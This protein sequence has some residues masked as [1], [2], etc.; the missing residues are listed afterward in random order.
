MRT[1]VSTLGYHETR[2]T[3]PV[4]SNGIDAGDQIVLVRPTSGTTDHRAQSAASYVAD[5]IQE[6]APDATVSTEHVDTGEFTETVLQCSDILQA[7]ES[8]RE[9]IVNFGGGAREV[10]LPLVLATVLHARSVDGA[11]QYTD[12]DQEV[13]KI[14]IPDLT[15]QLPRSAVETFALVAGQGEKQISLPALAR[16]SPQS[17][18]TVSRHVDTLATAGVINTW[19]EENT[20]HIRLSQTGQLLSRAG[21]ITA[22]RES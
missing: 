9:L 15:T 4:I 16:E 13:Q 3:R 11:F 10:L 22:L 2:V 12:V 7:I 6:V 14:A 20:K 5:M 19:L 1:Y 21:A 17:K 8:D 18:S